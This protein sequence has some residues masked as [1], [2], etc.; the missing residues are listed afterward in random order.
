MAE[1]SVSFVNDIKLIVDDIKGK[2]RETVITTKKAENI[3]LSQ[4]ES[5]RKTVDIFNSIEEHVTT[6]TTNLEQISDGVKNIERTKRDTLLAI[7]SISA[8]SEE[9]AAAT[10]E[11]NEAANKQLNAV[12][13]L[14]KEAEELTK[15]SQELAS[16]IRVFKID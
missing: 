4:G 1:Q 5:L 16:A 9:T 10:E 2:T 6:L 7:E 13:N 15:Q 14:S 11:V 12:I 3:V 8:V